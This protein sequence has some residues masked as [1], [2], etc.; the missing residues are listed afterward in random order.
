MDKSAS[1]RHVLG[2]DKAAYEKT[3]AFKAAI[4]INRL[5]MPNAFDS[6]CFDT[7]ILPR[8]H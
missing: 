2:H 3:I 5:Y 8:V 1:A 7:K 6:V 4:C